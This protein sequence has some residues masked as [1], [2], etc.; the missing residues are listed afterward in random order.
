MS[1]A[2][3]PSLRRSSRH[4]DDS[5]PASPVGTMNDVIVCKISAR[6]QAHVEAGTDLEH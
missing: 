2:S 5:A 1:P 4:D 3:S 6:Q